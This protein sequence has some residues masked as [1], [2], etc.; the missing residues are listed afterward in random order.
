MSH[1]QHYIFR[2]GKK[3]QLVIVDVG[4]TGLLVALVLF[5]LLRY[6]FVY[7]P[8]KDVRRFYSIFEYTYLS[9]CI[10][11]SGLKIGVK[12]IF[13]R[14]RKTIKKALRETR[15]TLMM[16]SQCKALIQFGLYVKHEC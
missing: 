3:H 7:I 15:K 1:S 12:K 9:W 14:P 5:Q 13:S 4:I 10:P 16:L 11:V 2:Y 8:D 6:Q